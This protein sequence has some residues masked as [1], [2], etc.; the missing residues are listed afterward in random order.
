[1]TLLQFGTIANFR[2]ESPPRFLK[3]ADPGFRSAEPV[4][5]R[6]LAVSRWL[7]ENGVAV[8]PAADEAAARPG[9]VDGAWAGLWVWRGHRRERPEPPA[10]GALLRQAPTGL[11]GGPG[12]L[13]G[14]AP[15]P[16]TPPPLPPPPA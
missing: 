13:P 14:N 4:L 11:A 15:P 5:E 7:D 2:V 10:A 3:V 16:A 1:M 12:P 9:A 8:A 6:S